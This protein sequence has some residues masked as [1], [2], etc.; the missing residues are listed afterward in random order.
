LP[1]ISVL[2]PNLHTHLNTWGTKY[3]NTCF[4]ICV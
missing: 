3:S 2:N 1:L 4:S